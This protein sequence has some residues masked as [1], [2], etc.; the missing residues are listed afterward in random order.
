ME[1]H[2][3]KNYTQYM[4]LPVYLVVISLV[5]KVMIKNI[6]VVIYLI[7]LCHKNNYVTTMYCIFIY[8]GMV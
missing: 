6:H 2:L 3:G 4:S 1:N 7:Y 5:V 8:Q